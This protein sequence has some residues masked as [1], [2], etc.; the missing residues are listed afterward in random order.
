MHAAFE[1]VAEH[2]ILEVRKSSPE[3]ASVELALVGKD[4]I[5]RQRMVLADSVFKAVRHC[6]RERSLNEAGR[7][8]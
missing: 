3:G 8:A 2:E 4:A 5:W 7:G 1:K 6:W